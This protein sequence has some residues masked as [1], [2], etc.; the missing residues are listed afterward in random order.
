MTKCSITK[1]KFS[2]L[3][4]LFRLFSFLADKTRGREMFVKPKLLLGTLLIGISVGAGV[5]SCNTTP[6]NHEGNTQP[7]PIVEPTCYDPVAPIISNT[8]PPTIHGGRAMTNVRD[9]LEQVPNAVNTPP[10][11]TCYKVATLPDTTK[12]DSLQN[13]D[14]QV[15]K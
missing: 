14:N 2:F 10:D 13:S 7:E 11:V 15:K 6:R 12:T 4:V 1:I 5:S 9:T 3:R 8:T